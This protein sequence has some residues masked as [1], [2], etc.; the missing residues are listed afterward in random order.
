MYSLKLEIIYYFETK[1]SYFESK[2]FYCETRNQKFPLL[3]SVN[4]TFK[5]AV[6]TFEI[7]QEFINSQPDAT[8]WN[9][10]WLLL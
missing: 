3:K 1:I 10:L 6:S 4:S 7:K 2:N 8:Y 9:L 5:Q